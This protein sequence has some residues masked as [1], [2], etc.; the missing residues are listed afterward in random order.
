[1]SPPGA[2]AAGITLL[3]ACADDDVIGRDNA[4]PWHLPDDLRHFRQT[5][6]GHVIVMGR[7][8]FDSIGRPLPGRNVIVLTRDPAW[9]HEGC[10]TAPGLDR[11]L[12]MA[13]AAGRGEIFVVGGAQ[14]YQ[15]ALP[16]ADRVLMTRIDLRVA[17]DAFFPALSESEWQ[18]A[19]RQEHVAASGLRYAIVDW[20]RRGAGG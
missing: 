1:M 10:A 4:L 17:G 7:R 6:L 19:S 20:R 18:V 15:E 14:V 2:P 12:A 9:L 13:A 16:R 3:V 11:A 5:T 8:T